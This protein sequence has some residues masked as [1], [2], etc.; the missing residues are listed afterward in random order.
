M[1]EPKGFPDKYPQNIP[2]D[3][4]GTVNM[5]SLQAFLPWAVKQKQPVKH[6]ILKGAEHMAILKDERTLNY[7][8]QFLTGSS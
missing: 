1:F 4:D 2:D 7:I 3:G 5:R 8:V 6:A